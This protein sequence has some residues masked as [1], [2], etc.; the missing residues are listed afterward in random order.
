MKVILTGI[1]T[2]LDKIAAD[3]EFEGWPDG[4]DDGYMDPSSDLEEK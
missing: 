4:W 1:L 2:L 3:K